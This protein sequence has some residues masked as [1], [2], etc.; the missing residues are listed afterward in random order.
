MASPLIRLGDKSSHGGTVLEA[1]SFTSGGGSGV[2]RVGDKV[3]CP[4]P[5]HGT[6][7]IVS[8]DPGMLVA[9]QQATLDRV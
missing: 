2:A 8:G 9:G 3:S 6:G 1:S 4:I 5:G 7:P